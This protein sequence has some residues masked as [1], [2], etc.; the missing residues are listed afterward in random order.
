MINNNEVEYFVFLFVHVSI[1]V[2]FASTV[3]NA[4]AI[5]DLAANVASI[6]HTLAMQ[7]PKDSNYF[8]YMIAA[9]WLGTSRTAT[10]R[11]LDC[12]RSTYLTGR[13]K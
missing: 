13:F 9:C 7:L 12:I 8:S 1:D 10:T 11:R 4:T 6:P 3:L 5:L 2:T